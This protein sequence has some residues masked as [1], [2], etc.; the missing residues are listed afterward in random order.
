[1]AKRVI[2]DVCGAQGELADAYGSIPDTWWTV[3]RKYASQ[4]CCST[5]CALELLNKAAAVEADAAAK[6]EVPPAAPASID[7]D[8]I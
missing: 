8:L 2:C 1:M 6:I 4:H 5:T 7:H 3:Q